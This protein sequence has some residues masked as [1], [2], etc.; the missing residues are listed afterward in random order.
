MGSVQIREVDAKK[1]LRAYGFAVPDGGLCI[2]SN[3]A[4]DTAD[5][6]GYPVAMKIVSKEI[7]HKSDVGGVKVNL[8]NKEAVRDAYDLMM[9]RIPNV[10][11][12]AQLDG[13]YVEQMAPRAER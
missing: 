12:E 1:V 10:M 8:Q 13:V 5:S 6:I 9:M 3:H 11:P 2:S 4:V 7:I